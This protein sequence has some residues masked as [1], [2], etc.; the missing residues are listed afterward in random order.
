MRMMLK[1]TFDVE[2]GNRAIEDG[3]LPKVMEE[4][5]SRLK[6]EASYF[7]ADGGDRAMLHVFDMKD[8]SQI[9]SV[10]EPLFFGMNAQVD[11]IPVM[12]YADL[13]KGLKAFMKSR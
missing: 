11:L 7:F 13:Q 3:T 1:V 8:S 10:V 4:T 9:P 6:P 2:T 5:I 12:N